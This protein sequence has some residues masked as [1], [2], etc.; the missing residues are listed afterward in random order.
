[1]KRWCPF[2]G[3]LY[4]IPIGHFVRY[5]K[6]KHRLKYS[7]QLKNKQTNKFKQVFLFVFECVYIHFFFSVLKIYQKYFQKYQNMFIKIFWPSL[8]E[9]IQNTATSVSTISELMWGW[10]EKLKRFPCKTH[11][12]HFGYN[13]LTSRSDQFL[14]CKYVCNLRPTNCFQFAIFLVSLHSLLPSLTRFVIKS[15]AVIFILVTASGV[16][17]FLWKFYPSL[18][19]F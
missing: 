12:S 19:S 15:W 2:L 14:W 3:K 13:T 8:A 17:L 5:S 1:M 7:S 10:R 18:L 11:P 9:N 16:T 6:M 4:K